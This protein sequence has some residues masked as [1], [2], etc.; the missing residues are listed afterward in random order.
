MVDLI[1]TVINYNN[2]NTEIALWPRLFGLKLMRDKEMPAKDLTWQ[3]SAPPSEIP[4]VL[5]AWKLYS[6]TERLRRN[7]ET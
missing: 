1:N 3:K 5:N 6:K 4:R 2:C 7:V